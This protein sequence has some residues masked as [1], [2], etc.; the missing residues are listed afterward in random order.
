MKKLAKLTALTMTVGML[1]AACGD[2]NDT[3]DDLPGMEDDMNGGL[4]DDGMDDGLGDDLED[5]TDE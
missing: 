2:A 5:D 3:D 4:E 1:L